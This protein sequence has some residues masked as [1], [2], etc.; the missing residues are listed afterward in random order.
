M[1]LTQKYLPDPWICICSD[2][3]AN[4]ILFMSL[5]NASGSIWSFRNVIHVNILT[6]LEVSFKSSFLNSCVQDLAPWVSWLLCWCVL[7][8]CYFSIF[9][10]IYVAISI[11]LFDIIL[12]FSTK[13]LQ[14][15]SDG[16]TLEAEAA[17]GTVTR[18][19]RLHQKGQ[20]TST[21]SIASIYAWTRGLE[22]RYFVAW[23]KLQILVHHD[24]RWNF[25][26]MPN[27]TPDNTALEAFLVNHISMCK[28][29]SQLWQC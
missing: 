5:W 24:I 2:L 9:F 13:N 4:L 12:R 21:N 3:V 11:W 25:G 26:L 15:S 19:F 28:S 20:E 16:K 22:H 17:H 29:S 8:S 1:A 18:H 27:S 6:Y 7:E 10:F 23:F 14:L